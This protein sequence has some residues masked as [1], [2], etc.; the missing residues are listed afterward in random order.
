MYRKPFLVEIPH[1]TEAAVPQI[2]PTVGS[3]YADR[4]EQIVECRGSHSQQGVARRSKADLLRPIF[5]DQ[6]ETAIGK[7]LTHHPKM[8]AA[9]QYPIL[10]DPFLG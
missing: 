7:R 8:V 6:A 10:F 4:L 1:L 9:G 5:E 3:E 2:E